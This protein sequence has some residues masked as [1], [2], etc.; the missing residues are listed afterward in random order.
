MAPLDRPKRMLV[1]TT[2]VAGSTVATLIGAQTLITVDSQNPALNNAFASADE[3]QIQSTVM[4][5]PQLA[6]PTATVVVRALPTIQIVHVAPSISIV[7][8]SG[9]VSDQAAQTVASQPTSVQAQAVIQPPVPVQIEPPAPVVV[10]QQSSNS[11]SSAAQQ[12]PPPRTQS[13]R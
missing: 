12:A 1:R 9:Q 11:Q 3:V 8:Q 5:I 2:I 10:Q 4:A 13:S 6:Q 7:R